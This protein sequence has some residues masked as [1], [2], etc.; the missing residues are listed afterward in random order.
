MKKVVSVLTAIL[1]LTQVQVF[2]QN[3]E[4]HNPLGQTL[5]AI[6]TAVPFLSIAPD[7]RA[8]A[9][10]DIGCA[11]SADGNS[12]S[13]NPAKYA[14]S[15]NAFGF[16]VSYSPW[17]RHLVNDINLAYLAGYW[18]ITDMDAI[19]ASLRY[20]SLGSIDFMD[21]YGQFISS[22]NPNEFAIDFT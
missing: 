13:Y 15:E 20:F 5:N 22:Q 19:G 18:R 17:L 11:T 21:E 8:G 14:F 4:G 10:G 6:T 7:S 9:M 1:I 3:D 16:T 12:Q 2:A